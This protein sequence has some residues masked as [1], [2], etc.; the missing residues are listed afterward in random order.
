MKDIYECHNLQLVVLYDV[1]YSNLFSSISLSIKSINVI[2][3]FYKFR[4]YMQYH[5]LQKDHQLYTPFT[6]NSMSLECINIY[7]ITSSYN[8]NETVRVLQA[9]SS[10]R[11]GSRQHI[12]N[13]S[14]RLSRY[15][16]P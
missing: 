15:H 12:L 4:Q 14:K 6:D 8:R 1:S 2:N 5:F 13:L 11:V 10:A 7:S 16:R 9:Y 3:E